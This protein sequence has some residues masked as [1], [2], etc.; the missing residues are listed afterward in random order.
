MSNEINTLLNDQPPPQR[1]GGISLGSIV[2]LAGIVFALVT[3]GITL[4]N[5]N[6]ILAVGQP[7][8]DFIL[9]TFDGEEVHLSDLRGQVVV[10]NF[11]ASWC[12]PCHDEAPDLQR[13]HEEYA[14]DGVVLIGIAWSEP[15]ETTGRE[16]LA[17]YD[18]DY[19]NGI[20]FGT[21]IGDDYKITGVPETFIIDRDGNLA[22]DGFFPGPVSF[23][24]LSRVL[25]N[26]LEA[27]TRS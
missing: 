22:E 25:D 23:I 18:I 10:V 21:R 27:G 19:I 2:L 24:T 8:P 26:T 7:V 12:G 5:Q 9:T 11:W 1:R 14:D 4:T 16:F 3:I 15:S 13:I 20:D 17:E 6:R